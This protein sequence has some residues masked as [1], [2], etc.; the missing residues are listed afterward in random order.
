[1]SNSLKVKKKLAKVKEK[2]GLR[3]M[4]FFGK[5]K[6]RIFCCLLHDD[7]KSDIFWRSSKNAMKRIVWIDNLK[8]NL[9]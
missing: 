2:K 4:L 6:K 1:M 9:K 8:V 5:E 3:K 7:L